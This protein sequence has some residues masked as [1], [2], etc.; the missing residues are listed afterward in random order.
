[1]VIPSCDLLYVYTCMSEES[2]VKHTYIYM[3]YVNICVGGY[4]FTPHR[5]YPYYPEV[6]LSY[7]TF[8]KPNSVQQ[9]SNH[10]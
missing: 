7:E 2:I 6:E 4:F 9:R 1:M 10:H 3:M 8:H 5:L